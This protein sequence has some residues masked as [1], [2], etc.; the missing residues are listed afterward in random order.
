ME[1]NPQ[2]MKG[3]WGEAMV[4]AFMLQ[5]G[6]MVF[7][8]VMSSGPIDL[9]AVHPTHGVAMLDVKIDTKRPKYYENG[10]RSKKGYRIYRPL[11]PLQ[12]WLRVHTAYVGEEGDIQMVPPVEGIDREHMTLPKCSKKERTNGV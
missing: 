10:N 3:G 9:I 4:T 6:W 11:K 2:H 1:F 8:N 5:R 7:N 12:K